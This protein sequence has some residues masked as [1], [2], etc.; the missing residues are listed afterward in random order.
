MLLFHELHKLLSGKTKWLVLSIL[1]VNSFVFYL[2]MM[3]YTRPAAERQLHSQVLARGRE[4][5][6]L[7]QA[8]DNVEA[9]VTAC[10]HWGS[11]EM[12]QY[13]DQVAYD[14]K[15]QY[16]EAINFAEFVGG[17]QERAQNMLDFPIFAKEGSFAKRNIIKTAADFKALE[18]LEVY[19][20]DG[21]GLLQMQKFFISDVFLLVLVCFLS[22]QL[23]GLD[24]STG[25]NKIINATPK[26]GRRL[27][28]VQVGLVGLCAVLCAFLLYGS[29]LLQTGLLAGFPA[30]SDDIHGIAAFQNIP[31]AC[32]T[33]QYLLSYLGWKMW[34]AL[35]LSLLVQMLAYKLQ[36]AKLA[37]GILGAASAASFLLWFYLP[38]NPIT[39]IFRYLNLF[40]LADTA[41]VIGNYQN[42]NLFGFPVELRLAASVMLAAFILVGGGLILYTK[43]VSLR[44]SL[45]RREKPMPEKSRHSLLGYEVR[46]TIGRQKGAILLLAALLYAGWAGILYQP[47]PYMLPIDYYYDEMSSSLVGKSGQELQAAME[48]LQNQNESFSI[49][50]QAEA[51]V[52][53]QQQYMLLTRDPSLPF[54]NARSWDAVFANKQKEIVLFLVF[55][56]LAIFSVV[57]LFQM[58]YRSRMHTLIRA[59][60]GGGKV[61]WYKFGCVCVQS[62]V[63][64][65]LLHAG[66]LVQYAREYA[67]SMGDAPARSLPLFASTSLSASIYGMLALVLV[68]KVLAGLCVT[69][70]LFVLAQFLL[71]ASQFII[72]AGVLVLLPGVLLYI[73]NMQYINPLVNILKMAVEPCLTLYYALCSWPSVQTQVP[74]YGFVCMVL[75]AFGLVVAGYY[76]WQ[77]R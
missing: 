40:G 71:S 20:T 57:G 68:Q 18:G 45:R 7:Q 3:P 16:Q 66:Q 51:F 26:G 29:N 34:Y 10:A 63:F 74:V 27:L 5:D 25:I 65:L 44:L 53:I 77:K 43:P 31:Y 37:W 47:S 38:A 69:M 21:E 52:K 8:M 49:Q 23:F 6:T 41:E 62:V 61:Y 15:N 59:T 17:F 54:V 50:G 67:P 75:A 2:Y 39:K 30:F 42:L 12:Y 56:L 4:Y 36:G 76:R 33:L 48:A 9:D 1:L 22:F 14:L 55:S 72:G 60:R 11:M 28:L 58:E 13:S 24:A 35:G 19:P 64:T 73:A 46:K 32:T 70:L